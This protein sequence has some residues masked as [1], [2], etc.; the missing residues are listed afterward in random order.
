MTLLHIDTT[1]EV[2]SLA[3]SH[4]SQIVLYRIDRS[5]QNH[6]R[7][8]PLFMQEAIEF[9]L[10]NKLCLDAVALSRGPGSYTGL[11]IGT[12]TAKGLCYAL[13]IPLI[14]VDTLRIMCRAVLQ[15]MD[16]QNNDYLCPMIDAR[17][18]EVY[19]AL[20]D[21]QLQEIISVQA[22]VVDE[23][24]FAEIL[25]T[26]RIL[27]F[28][29]G[30]SKCQGTITSKNAVFITG[31][32]P[33]AQYMINEAEE[34]FAIKQFEDTAYFDPFYLKDFQATMPKNKIILG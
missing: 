12:S 15:N 23:E 19:D 22:Q 18:M 17:R 6:A 28:G 31:I 30:A 7:M 24:A 33:D 4:D 32:E 16:V 3:V 2:C 25:T 20:Y 14:A 9:L 21:R 34:R 1:T 10:Q 27:F 8:L 29:N 5:G 26:K 11:R 13:D